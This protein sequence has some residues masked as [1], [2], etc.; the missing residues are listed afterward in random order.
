M[1]RNA[2]KN[3][4]KSCVWETYWP[5]IYKLIYMAL[6]LLD[7]FPIYNNKPISFSSI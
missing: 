2:V 4:Y 3:E 7:T 5:D 6:K 1:W